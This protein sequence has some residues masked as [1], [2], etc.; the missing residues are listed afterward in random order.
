MCSLFDS[1][2]VEICINNIVE[3]EACING[4]HEALDMSIKDLTVCSDFILIISQLTE[5][6]EVRNIINQV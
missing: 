1:H 2:K 4:S 6:K 5:E 3:Y